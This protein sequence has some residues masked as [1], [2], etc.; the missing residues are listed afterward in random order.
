MIFISNHLN[1][2]VSLIIPVKNEGQHIQNTI[3]SALEVRTNYSF[4]IVVVDDNSS[5]GCCEF[6]NNYSSAIQIK[7][8]KSKGIGAARARNLGAKNSSGEYLIFCDAHVCFEDFWIEGLLQPIHDGIAD[9]TTP[10]IA[11]IE[12]PYY[13]GYGQTL[14]KHLGV[15]WQVEKTDP[16]P[17]A[18][19]P[20]GCY[21]VSRATFFDIGGFDKGFQV[22]GHED[23]EISLKM[24]LFGYTCYVQPSVTILHIF[25]TKTPY[26][27]KYEHVY[28]NMLR[29]VYS[30]FK[31]E[32]IYKFREIIGNHYLSRVEPW[33]LKSGVLEQRK[34]Y[35][36]RRKYND[37]WYMDKFSIDF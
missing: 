29:M 5:D 24:W 10:G 26:P 37:D 28:F 3:K 15:E 4:E 35:I 2:L 32:R 20:A 13:P 31:K 9:G 16:F 1:S 8:I 21:A 30:H 34:L 17:T 7:L 12:R 18:V 25:R 23:V 11:D 14:N 36:A 33:V 6:L 27:L 22:W 19:L